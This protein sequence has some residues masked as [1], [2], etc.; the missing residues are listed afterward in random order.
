[1]DWREAA[2][3]NSLA[4][5]VSTVSSNL[6]TFAAAEGEESQTQEQQEQSKAMQGNTP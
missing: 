6:V 5:Q 1:L 2:S 4:F 3:D